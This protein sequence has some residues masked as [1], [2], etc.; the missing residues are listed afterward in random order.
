MRIDHDE[1]RARRN[2]K[3]STYA[4]DV[5]P[6]WVAEMDLPTDP[7]VL[8]ALHAAVDDERLGYPPR[9]DLTDVPDAVVDWY[10]NRYDGEPP[11][12]AH[13]HLVPDVLKGV[14]LGIEHYAAPGSAV[15]LPTPAYMP[16]FGVCANAGREVVEVPLV[17]AGLDLDAIDTALA[18]GAGTVVLCHPHNP[19]GRVF[20]VENLRG[21]AEIVE[22]HGARVVSDE[23]HGPIVYDD[24]HVPYASVSAAATGHT[25]TVT[26]AS[27]AWNLPGLKCAVAITHSEADLATWERIPVLRTEG[28]SSLGIAA[29]EAAFVRG[30]PWLD[31]TI[32][33]LD[34]NRTWF[35]ELLAERLPDVGYTPPAATYFAWLDC[36]ALDLPDEPAA[37]FLENAG[38]A[39]NPGPPFGRAGE[40]FVRVNL[41]TSQEMLEEL[42]ARMSRS[43]DRLRP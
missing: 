29:T 35:A 37:W 3:W 23:V 16:F 41:A 17:E 33:F 1:M 6:A 43:L 25:L 21:L 26:A 20:D 40:G 39:V 27:K 30:G 32:A 4:D 24:E 13:V 36:R 10:R 7:V 11:D 18:Q 2:R 31:E 34:E 42:V 5:L 12:P 8:S 9:D 28:T 22:R 14:E 15:V 38:V 19:T